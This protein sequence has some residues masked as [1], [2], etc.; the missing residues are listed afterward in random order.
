MDFLYA[1]PAKTM[2]RLA[3]GVRLSALVM[4][5][6]CASAF[7]PSGSRT[8]LMRTSAPRVLNMKMALAEQEAAA[9]AVT[10]NSRAGKARLSMLPALL[11]LIVPMVAVAA[12]EE[13]DKRVL[14]TAIY[15][16]AHLPIIVPFLLFWKVDTETK[17]KGA[18]VA[19]PFFVGW[20]ALLG[21]WLRF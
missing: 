16:V 18:A 2:S 21:G 13:E 4:T 6:A 7:V 5:L 9:A 15:T 11:P 10:T 19:S 14:Y 17:I 8:M 3:G 20:I 1:T 12:G